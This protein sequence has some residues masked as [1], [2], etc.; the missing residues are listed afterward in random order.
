MADP[1][2]EI[3]KD[4]SGQFR[5]RLL[6]PNGEPIAA[7]EAYTTK[8]ACRQGIQSVKT[9][10]PRARKYERIPTKK[11]RDPRRVFLVH[12]RNLKASG[13]MEKF[14]FSIGLLPLDFPEARKLTGKTNPYVHDVLR[15][16]FSVTQ[17]IVVLMTP[18]DVGCLR[19]SFRRPDEPSSETQFSPQARQNV[20]F[21]AGMAIGLHL[22]R[23]ILVELGTL[24]PFSDIGGRHVVRLDNTAE[25]RKLLIDSLDT[26]KCRVVLSSELWK[27]EGDFEGAISTAVEFN[28]ELDQLL[29]DE[30]RRIGIDRN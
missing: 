1:Q 9:S 19:Q 10:A 13:A 16:A 29:F 2:F 21:E 24:R 17:A 25:K 27:T 4:A 8:E 22:N 15:K 20:I 26:A 6:A 14:L 12:G 5:W 3:F 7:S 28:D 18:D 23:T 30:T 11:R